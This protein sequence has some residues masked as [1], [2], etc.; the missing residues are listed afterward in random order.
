MT[1][2]TLA[3]QALSQSI[4]LSGST[5]LAQSL[6][7]SL[8]ARLLEVAHQHPLL[9]ALDFDGV[10]APL[11]DDPA[12]VTPLPETVAAIQRLVA[13]GIPVAVVSGRDLASLGS[14]AQ[15]GPGVL[16][17]GSHGDE[18]AGPARPGVSDADL[19][20]D[21]DVNANVVHAAAVAAHRGAAAHPGAWVE[22]KRSS[23]AVHV[24]RMPSHLR[25]AALAAARQAL[26]GIP[27]VRLLP[28]NDVLEATTTPADKGVAVETLRAMSGAAAVIFLGDDVTDEAAFARLGSGDLG[29]KVGAGD[30]CAAERVPDCIAVS[31]VL[32]T[33]ADHIDRDVGMSSELTSERTRL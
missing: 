2:P 16:M 30:T 18:W 26:H 12:A 13:H 23:V 15:I 10:V 4:H 21:L 3:N 32:H 14:V 5:P 28:G 20:A 24:R 1:Q 29:I 9:V 7:E 27:G 11:G 25:A 19:D 22:L 8:S 6:P 17:V 31:H 33:L